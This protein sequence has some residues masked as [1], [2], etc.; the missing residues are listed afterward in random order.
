ML[1]AFHQKKFKAM[2]LYL[3]WYIPDFILLKTV[4]CMVLVLIA[5]F[6]LFSSP[7][8]FDFL[9]YCIQRFCESTHVNICIPMVWTHATYSLC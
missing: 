7:N 1:I 8:F 9:E 4:D 2:L 3:F 5:P 6:L